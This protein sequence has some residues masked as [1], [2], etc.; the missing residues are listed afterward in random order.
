MAKCSFRDH[1]TPCNHRGAM[2][3]IRYGCSIQT[4]DGWYEIKMNG[5]SFTAKQLCKHNLPPGYCGCS[6]YGIY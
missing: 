2:A 1:P 6:D 3:G 4:L 5:S